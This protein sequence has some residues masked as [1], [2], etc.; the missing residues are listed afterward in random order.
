[1]K[2]NAKIAGLDISDFFRAS[3]KQLFEDQLCVQ[4]SLFYFESNLNS[5]I[6]LFTLQTNE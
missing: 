2:T 3:K 5:G 1:M 4:D 6:Y